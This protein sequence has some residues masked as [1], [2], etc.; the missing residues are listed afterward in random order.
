[1]LSVFADK[2]STSQVYMFLDPG[3]QNGDTGWA[4]TDVYH[5][6]EENPGSIH[7]KVMDLAFIYLLIELS[8]MYD[9]ILDR[10][11]WMVP[12]NDDIDSFSRVKQFNDCLM[13]PNSSKH[14]MTQEHQTVPCY[15]S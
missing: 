10:R 2:L 6:A 13:V 11:L 12:C 9:I 3:L 1:M 14:C 15:G 5:L 4:I 7:V 8:T